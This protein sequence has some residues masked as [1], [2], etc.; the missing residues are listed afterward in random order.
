MQPR[1]RRRCTTYAG[2][3][4]RWKGV[5]FL[6][7]IS[8][9]LKIFLFL[10][11]L[12]VAKPALSETNPEIETYQH[13]PMV[14]EENRGQTDPLVRYLSRSRGATLFLTDSE[15]VA[16]LGPPESRSVIRVSF[17]GANPNAKLEGVDTLPG[18]TNYYLGKDPRE[19]RENIPSYGGVAQRDVYPGIDLV[20]RGLSDKLE[21]DFIVAPGADPSRITLAFDGIRRVQIDSNGDL[22]TETASG[23]LIHRK[24]HVYQD[25]GSIRKT[26]E[27]RWLVRAGN[28]A[29]F[30]L[31]A[32]DRSRPLVIDPVLD[33]ST[34][35]GGRGEDRATKVIATPALG[36]AIIVGSTNSLDFP[37]RSS[38]QVSGG[39]DIFVAYQNLQVRSAISTIYIGGSGDDKPNAVSAT[40]VANR[41]RL[42]IAGET[43]SRNFP[44]RA[45]SPAGPVT[46]P[47]QPVQATYGGGASDAFVL[48]IDLP[49]FNLTYS[50]YL[51]GAGDDRA[52]GVAL[53]VSNRAYVTGDTNSVN[54]PTRNPLQRSLAGGV[55]AFVTQIASGGASMV[56][57]TYLGGT[58]DDGG[59]AITV[60]SLGEAYV[61]GE[62][63]SKDLPTK[64]AFQAAIVGTSDAFFT[65]LARDGSSLSFCSYL[66]GAGSDRASGIRL[67][68]AQ[69]IYIGGTTASGDFPT[70]NAMQGSFGG[71]K[72]DGFLAR[73]TADASALSYSTFIGGSGDEEAVALSV[74]AYGDAYL[75]GGTNSVDLPTID[76][77]QPVFAGGGEDAFLAHLDSSGSP[78]HVTYF[79]G[80]GSD[81]ALGASVDSVGSVWIAG[82]TDSPDLPLKAPF[83]DSI[84]G[85]TDAFIVKIS[86]PI[87]IVPNVTIGKDLQVQLGVAFGIPPSTD[88]DFAVTISTSDPSRLLVS[89][90]ANEQGSESIT[91]SA[92]ALFFLQALDSAGTVQYTV[93]APGYVTRTATVSLVPSGFI[94]QCLPPGYV[95]ACRESFA[96]PGFIDGFTTTT[97]SPNT[98]VM[99]YAVF[100]DPATLKA[101][102]IETLRGG[103]SDFAVE[104][105]SSNPAVG[106]VTTPSLTFK[107]AYSQGEAEFHPISSGT[108]IL[109]ASTP[110][111]FSTPANASI[112]VSVTL[113]GLVLRNVVPL[114]KDLQSQAQLAVN[115]AVG[116]NLNAIVT[117]TSE[118]PSRLAV[119]PSASQ[120][121]GA[122][123]T[124]PLQ[125]FQASQAS[126]WVQA[127]SD[128]GTVR[129]RAS[130]AGFVDATVAVTLV[131]S[132]F[133]MQTPGGGALDFTTTTLSPDS[134]IT[135]RPTPLDPGSLMPIAFTGSRR[136]GAAS[137]Q[138]T[139]TSSDSNVG[140]VTPSVTFN[141]GDSG[142]Q[143]QFHPLAV[144]YTQLTLSIP[145]GFSTPS[146]GLRST[147]TVVA[148]SI[149]MQDTRVGMNLQ[150][151]VSI[152]LTAA[153]PAGGLVV[154]ISNSGAPF[155]QRVL[156]SA[157]N[158][159]TAGQNQVPIQISAGQSFASF[160]VQGLA[161]SGAVQLTA[162]APGFNSG[163]M[164]ITLAPSGFVF[165]SGNEINTTLFGV[166]QISLYPALLDPNTGLPVG[167]GTL[168][169][170][171]SGVAVDIASSSPG[172][173]GVANLPLAFTAGESS[174]FVSFRGS[175]LG[176]TVLTIVPP[177]GFSTA[178]RGSQTRVNVAAP[179]LTIQQG[180]TVGKDLQI[181][182]AVNMPVSPP[183]QHDITITSS[184]P[185]KILLSLD[186]RS[187]GSQSVTF[188]NGTRFF[189]QALA[190][191]GT[192]QLTASAPDFLD[193]TTMVTLTPSGFVISQP[194]ASPR[195]GSLTTTTFSPPTQVSVMLVP[196]DR[197]ALALL[198]S[199]Q[200]V[201]GGITG[202]TV[203]V[204]S[205][206]P[207]VGS[208]TVSPLTFNGGDSSKVT[209]FR[210][211]AP[212]TAT[213]SLGTPGGFSTPAS[214][215]DITF[216]V[217]P[218]SLVLENMT[219]GLNLQRQASVGLA[220]GVTVPANGLT[221]TVAS[222]DPDRVLLATSP[223]GPGA[224]S[225]Q[226]SMPPGFVGRTSDFYVRG[227]A[228]EGTVGLAI[229]ADGFAD[230]SSM[231]KLAPAGF[232]LGFFSSDGLRTTTFAPN[233]RITVFASVLDPTAGS[234]PTQTVRGDV[235]D[236]SVDVTSS[237]PSIGVV[238]GSPVTFRGGDSQQSVQFQP[239]APGTVVLSASVPDGF[240]EPPP[241]QKQLRV[242]VAM[243]R[244]SLNLNSS[245]VGKDLQVSGFVSPET[246]PGTPINATL[247]SSD[248]TKIL[249]STGAFVA[250]NSSV[251]VTLG[252]GSSQFFVQ[253]LTDR[254]TATVTVSAPG[255]T[256]GSVNVTL[257]PTG[258]TL[259]NQ[260][261]LSTTSLSPDT[262]LQIVPTVLDP[263]TLG[264]RTT[265]PLR[266]GLS[267]VQVN[268][269]SSDTRVGN[270]T[271]SPVVFNGGDQYKATG[272]HPVGAGTAVITVDVPAGFSTP[273]GQRQVL[274]TVASPGLTMYSGP[275]GFN[276]QTQ[277]T[278]NLTAPA[279][280]GLRLTITSTDPSKLLVSPSSLATG[281]GS[282]SLNVFTG[283]TTVSFW[284]QA[285]GSSGTVQVT[286][287]APG[288]NNG[289]V[290]V[291]LYPSGFGFLFFG[292]STMSL[293][294]GTTQFLYVGTVLLDPQT[295]TP[296]GTAPQLRPGLAP[297]T[298]NV[299][300]SDPTVAAI[301]GSPL[302]FSGGDSQKNIWVSGV[303][304]G[305]TT[306]SIS[307]PAGFS[308]PASFQQ[309]T[310]TV[311]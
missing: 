174:K 265:Q 25:H 198:Y 78:I 143:A 213:V 152:Q 252:Q 219:V 55:D 241:A 210:P 57:S 225:I 155:P 96:T 84:A 237:D 185:D 148:P 5:G 147:V 189:V 109:T 181:S 86:T 202:L 68:S 12:F 20:Y 251:T 285:L 255:F 269:T 289:S 33:Y 89:K 242:T 308:A 34:Y 3:P 162:S 87:L 236:I 10:L 52:Y 259:Q 201:R 311:R 81:R 177:T 245:V 82:R 250:G 17:P 54:F 38:Q 41:I 46:Q 300:S 295:L 24:P 8:R 61:A 296:I 138:L 97:I 85:G 170:G 63:E 277:A 60:N 239:L 301:T 64:N 266:A 13:L 191:E 11:Q 157:T 94:V 222:T 228:G 70:I 186:S 1:V 19:W 142:Q 216:R 66:G 146:T 124:V 50:T 59:R 276:L 69:N 153:A 136:A 206:D 256:S 14:F 220:P 28:Q 105:T 4:R 127:L 238:V 118:D 230:S 115:T 257:G 281:S 107:S 223:R 211:V 90:N 262:T 227:L 91:L 187:P 99:V 179:A 137:V 284:V 116:S 75:V 62:T 104:V 193:A 40:T 195:D 100:L 244:L 35:L 278:I 111:G 212:G 172:I 156:L 288:F 199:G 117:I 307:T 23:S 294:R 22:V 108:T 79:G 273:A 112:T 183:T 71:G 128:S 77:L 163:N 73:F 161:S 168:R 234:Y 215:R 134:T 135:I 253:S 270:I 260:A 299:T 29:G 122:N 39:L 92:G 235:P 203:D 6:I 272:F 27:G 171:L 47:P 207:G 123:M 303:S 43:N 45:E 279:P 264:V 106:T 298:V 306:I 209:L 287:S 16:T 121:G 205:S 102:G 291:L 150:T 101:S 302:A 83:Q 197:S 158:S 164:T 51:G 292:G 208:V 188:A 145:Q 48:Q 42:G 133:F 175:G 258:F 286:A 125:G 141:A 140:T 190:S 310:A 169:A 204:I 192:V 56:Y 218:P 247:S 248:P 65:K 159:N 176:S 149:K 194:V 32:Y 37:N 114:G 275:V 309:I 249:L 165:S 243:P 36:T 119:S 80:S 274:A 221:V 151:S 180:L 18:V 232:V 132:G 290:D 30:Q 9:P 178:A 160:V 246:H 184:D 21:Y 139:L 233:T 2:V 229:S 283:A 224:A 26:I 154:T 98:A 131:P 44:T 261:T 305:I 93:S 110:P 268:V 67:D 304:P 113:P 217:T 120:P 58:A 254:G 49:N 282:I 144:G 72:T 263:S 173:G 240:S 182:S 271:T 293:S 280:A 95:E 88:A 200:T 196:L 129:L 226:V 231:V 31:G 130:A 267:G 15:A 76:P 53:D 74:T 103:L 214:S 166:A 126:F 297:F 7:K 167:S